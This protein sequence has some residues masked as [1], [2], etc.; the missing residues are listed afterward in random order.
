M[1]PRR[2]CAQLCRLAPRSPC[3]ER[4]LCAAGI[5]DDIYG[6]NFVNG[7]KDGNVQDQNGHGSF[8]AGVVGAVGNNGLGV[9]GINQARGP[10]ADG[11]MRCP[12]AGA[13]AEWRGRLQA[14]SVM[15]CRF[16]DSTGNGW[17]SDAIRCFEYCLSKDAHV[18]SNS[19]GGVD[20][21]KS[22]QVGPALPPLSRASA[23]WVSSPEPPGQGS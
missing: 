8:V 1:V 21:S 22:L 14:A 13:V 4:R 11:H 12:C 17:V 2:A 16:M 10:G 7:G 20:Y 15:T 3:A 23:L 9:T 19:W 18:M 5:I 6:A